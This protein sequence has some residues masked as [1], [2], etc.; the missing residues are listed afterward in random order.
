MYIILSSLEETWDKKY[1]LHIGVGV[2]E[3]KGSSALKIYQ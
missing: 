2:T 3:K 1:D